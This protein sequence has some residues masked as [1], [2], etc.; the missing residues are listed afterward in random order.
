MRRHLLTNKRI[1]LSAC[2]LIIICS[3][4]C[5]NEG[6]QLKKIGE[7]VFETDFVP[8]PKFC[9]LFKD[10][11][12]GVEYLYLSNG[13]TDKKV[14]F[15][16]LD[17]KR[18]KTIDYEAA[19]KGHALVDISIWSLDTILALSKKTGEVFAINDSG[20]CIKQ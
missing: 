14:S 5:Q 8:S 20:K 11:M 15:F 6:L 19:T 18:H 1:F 16:T 4:S 2:L 9:G 7:Q 17:G 3:Q 10:T 12:T 13:A